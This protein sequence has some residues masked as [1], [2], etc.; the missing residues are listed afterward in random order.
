MGRQEEAEAGYRQALRV[1]PDFALAHNNLG[2]L[3]AE[4]GRYQEA[5]ASIGEALR[6]QPDFVDAHEGRGNAHMALGQWREA[7]AS[8]RS[9]LRLRPDQATLHNG[10]GVALARQRRFAD[11]DAAFRAA[12]GLRPDSADFVNNL[13]STLAEQDRFTEAEACYQEAL[14]RAP[15]NH[16]THYNRGRNFAAQSKRDEAR[17]CYENAIRIKADYGDAIHNLGV[18]SSEQGYLDRAADC[19]RK[20]LALRPDDQVIRSSLLLLSHYFADY[21]PEATFA[22]HLAWGQQVEEKVSAQRLSPSRVRD[23]QRRLRI[24]YVSGDF[25]THVMGRYSE[26]VIAA[27]DRGQVE[28]FCYAN[29]HKEDEYS[30]R[31]RAAADHWRSVPELPDLHLAEL[32]L[33]DEID[34]LVDLAGHTGSNRLRVFALK[35]AP[36]QVTHCGYPD[37][38]GLAAIDY[39]LTD[40]HCDPPGQTERWYREKVVHLPETHWCYAPPPH[41][42]EVGPLPAR[43]PGLVTF[44]S[45]NNPAKITESM[46]GVWAKILS[47]LPQSRL[48]VQTGVGRAGDE[49]VLSV[50]AAHGIA[51]ER[52]RFLG[53]EGGEAYFRLYHDVDI[54]LDTY[55][56]AGCNITADALWMGVPVVTRAGPTCVTRL[57]LS[58]IVLAGLADL[59]THTP[60][61]Y[62]QAAVRLAQD[63]P[64]LRELRGQLRER[65]RSTLGNVPRFTRQ[66][67]AVYRQMWKAYCDAER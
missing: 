16:E 17:A 15:E 23:P 36:V 50:F 22:E 28:V 21:D 1:R 42:P 30:R 7:E 58:A 2:L 11:A 65:V 63:L 45:F 4:E 40:P 43:E 6:L 38:T 33:A 61:A 3:L 44:A 5:L 35:P 18:I 25:H 13:G 19:Y 26:A 37:T 14:R 29:L 8:Y 39:R 59:V 64:R 66:L 57:G 9:A 34:I 10:L 54:C 52:V 32:I 46:I 12:L 60:E 55:P 49:R 62:V 27:H 47:E 67:E 51:G 20:A 53:R 24:G 41:T 48:V 31:I 56:Y